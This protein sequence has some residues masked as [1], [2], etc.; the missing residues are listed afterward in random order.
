MCNFKYSILVHTHADP[1]GTLNWPPVITRL[2]VCS[3]SVLGCLVSD[4]VI[5]VFCDVVHD[6][7]CPYMDQALLKNIH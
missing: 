3:Y 1:R 4:L 5:C 6:V 7:E 2:T